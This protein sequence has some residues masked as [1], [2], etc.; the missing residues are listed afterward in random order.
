MLGLLII[1]TA[2]KQRYA[3]R[4]CQDLISYDMPMSVKCHD[5][6]DAERNITQILQCKD[7]GHILYLG[8]LYKQDNNNTPIVLGHTLLQPCISWVNRHNKSLAF[9]L[10][11][12]GFD[13]WILSFRGSQ[14]SH[15]HE[16]YT[17]ND[18]EFW[19]FGFYELGVYDVSATVNFVKEK[20]GKK[21]IYIGYS[22]GSTAGYAYASQLPEESSRSLQ[23]MV[24]LSPLAY[25]KNMKS[26]SRYFIPLTPLFRS[27]LFSIGHGGSFPNLEIV[28]K[29][30]SY[31]AFQLVFCESLKV[32]FFGD[33]FAQLD[34]EY[35]PFVGGVN[36]DTFAVDLANNL[37][38]IQNTDIF[39]GNDYGEDEN[40]KR[41]RQ[42]S[43]PK[44]DLSEI[45]VPVT[46]V[47]G[48]NDWVATKKN[49]LRLYSELNKN[50]QCELIKVLDEKWNY[51]NFVEAKDITQLLYEPLLGAIQKMIE[52]RC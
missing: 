39:Q 8:R 17:T 48:E 21:P 12:H 10:A 31:Y 11:D 32:P 7:D 30:C 42:A 19:K 3:I 36:H 38:V 22:T 27:L 40:F 28:R 49:V 44:F 14:Y 18:D 51:N 9:F 5:D 46:L 20:T 37:A 6:P 43:P 24:S 33:N 2:F 25:L 47:W 45:K 35:L 23:G 16:K 26:Y 52:E 1:C 29:F 15:G 50:V 34:P 41:Y 13:V 4:V